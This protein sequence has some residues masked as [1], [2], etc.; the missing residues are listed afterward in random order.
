MVTL[1]MAMAIPS[2]SVQMCNTYWEIELF[3]GIL[4]PVP[5]EVCIE[6]PTPPAPNM[7]Q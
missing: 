1:A 5:Y 3:G 6:V 4:V 7:T 2:Y